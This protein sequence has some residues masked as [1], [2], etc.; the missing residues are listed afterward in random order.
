MVV[1]E[2]KC[3]MCGRRFEAEALDRENPQERHVHGAPLRCP[4]CQSTMLEKLRVI[5]RVMRR[6]P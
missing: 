4:N 5:R 1:I 2:M 6:I 3:T